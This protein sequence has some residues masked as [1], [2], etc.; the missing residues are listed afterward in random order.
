MDLD[1]IV[2]VYVKIRD[3]KARIKREA[4]AAC[5]DLQSKLD[6]LE[7]EILRG[8]DALTVQSVRTASGTAYKKEEIKPSCK[9]WGVL[10]DWVVANNIPPAEVFEKRLSKKFVVDYMGQHE[11]AVPPAVAVHRQYEVHVRR[12]D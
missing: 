3:E 7:A 8:L 12:G 2:S 6:R 9:D 5:A 4:D 10:S 1:K 11:G